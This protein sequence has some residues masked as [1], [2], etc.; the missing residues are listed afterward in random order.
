MPSEMTMSVGSALPSMSPREALARKEIGFAFTNASR[1]LG[2]VAGS[3]NT[4]L[5]NV[6]GNST[7][8]PALRTAFGERSNSPR[9][10][11]AHARP[12]E[13]AVTSARARSTPQAP[14]SGRNPRMRKITTTD[15]AGDYI[16]DSVTEEG[17]YERGGAPDWQRSEPV[18]NTFCEIGVE[19]NS[20]V[21]SGE[22]HRHDQ[23]AGKDVVQIGGGGTAD[24]A[25]EEVREHQHEHHR[26]HGH[27]EELFGNVFYLEHSPPAEHQRG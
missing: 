24:C 2:S 9:R 20:R 17:S 18:H 10:M 1:A 23:D 6:S 15:A 8:N 21:D 19:G 16:A 5:R 26:R 25:T 27:V 12:N 4:L 11:A 22:E 7:V 14:A 13:N 3:T